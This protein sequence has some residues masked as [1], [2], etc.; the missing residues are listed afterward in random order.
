MCRGVLSTRQQ[1]SSGGC[2]GE[3][4][5]LDD[6]RVVVDVQGSSVYYKFYGRTIVCN[7]AI[8]TVT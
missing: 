5:P 4:C 7:C 1:Q 2:A 3:F 8:G 6:N